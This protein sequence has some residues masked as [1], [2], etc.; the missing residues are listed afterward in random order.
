MKRLFLILA[1]GLLTLLSVSAFRL[2]REQM[3]RASE[4]ADQ[5]F[6]VKA[7]L[8]LIHEKIRREQ[9]NG[10]DLSQ[11]TLAQLGLSGLQYPAGDYTFSPTAKGFEP[12]VIYEGTASKAKGYRLLAN[13][14]ITNAETR[15]GGTAP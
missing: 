7:D 1:V 6:A 4:A 3:T 10:R 8:E 2:V 9:A 14:L 5:R 13:G 15:T 12:M 11:V